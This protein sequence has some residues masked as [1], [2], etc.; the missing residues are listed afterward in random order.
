MYPAG[1]Y[2]NRLQFHWIENES[3]REAVERF[4]DQERREIEQ[5]IDGLMGYSPYRS[6][7]SE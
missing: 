1:I 6:W 4:V 7:E 2:A 3:F 5:E